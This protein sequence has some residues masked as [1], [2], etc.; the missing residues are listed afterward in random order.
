MVVDDSEA[1]R[2][3][4]GDMIES[5][6][7]TIVAVADGLDQALAAYQAHRPDLVT[8]DISMVGHDGMA[9]F[10]ALK[11]LDPKVKVLVISGNSQKKI[12]DA[13]LAAGV[14]GYVPKPINPEELKSKIAS[15]AAA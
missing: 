6:G 4:I 10:N 9:V 2:I 8:M 11:K 1:M 14:S 5:F 12:Y 15:L 7:H 13:L 3:M